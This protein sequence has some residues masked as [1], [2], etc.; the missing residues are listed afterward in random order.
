MNLIAGGL[1]SMQPAQSSQIE[2]IGRH[3]AFALHR[4]AARTLEDAFR[5]C[6]QGFR[7]ANGD[8]VLLKIA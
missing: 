8:Q 5:H 4:L 7:A 6:Y 1:R 2:G 3:C